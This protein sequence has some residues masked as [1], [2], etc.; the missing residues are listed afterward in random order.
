MTESNRGYVPFYSINGGTTIMD[1]A[2]INLVGYMEP[3]LLFVS[4]VGGTATVV[5]KSALANVAA[6]YIDVSEGG[7]TASTIRVLPLGFPYIY[8]S[9]AAISGATVYVGVSFGMDAHKGLLNPQGVSTVS[10]GLVG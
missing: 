1:G 2:V 8:A 6:Q 9:I 10:G 7:Y 3:P 4:I 5:V